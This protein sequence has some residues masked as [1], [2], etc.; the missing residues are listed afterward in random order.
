MPEARLVAAGQQPRSSWASNKVPRRS[1][2]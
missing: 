1:R 2:S